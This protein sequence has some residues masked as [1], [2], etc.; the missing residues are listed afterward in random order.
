[1][2]LFI[3][4]GIDGC[5]HSIAYYSRDIPVFSSMKL[6]LMGS[7]SL[8]LALGVPQASMALDLKKESK[9]DNSCVQ[10]WPK[11]HGSDIP[12]YCITSQNQVIYRY[13]VIRGSMYEEPKGLV[14]KAEN[15]F[16]ILVQYEVEYGS[17]V[18]YRCSPKDTNSMECGDEIMVD[19]FIVGEGWK[20]VR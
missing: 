12:G 8:A 2:K 10:V 19:K 14:G 15:V 3:V 9:K 18:R 5:K 7:I 16:G 4:G 20:N 17:L 11:N 6:A 1:M 13:G